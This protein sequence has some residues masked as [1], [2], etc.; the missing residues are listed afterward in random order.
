M[1]RCDFLVVG[2]GPAG[3]KAAVQAAKAGSQ[4]VLVEQDSALGGACVRRGTIPSKTLRETALALEGF[5]RRSGG[6]F[7][8]VLDEQQQVDSLMLRKDDVLAAHDRFLG[9]QLRRNGVDVWHGR[10]RF[11]DAHTLEVQP[12]VGA[13]RRVSAPI[14]IIATGSRPRTPPGIPVDHEHV[15]DSDSILSLAYLPRSLAVLG[16]GVIA[17]EYASIFAAL[18]VS[19]TVIDKAPRPLG[20]L[21]EEITDRWVSSFGGRFIGQV[22]VARVEWDGVSQVVTTLDSGEQVVTEKL[23]CALGRV[24]NVEQLNLPA[25][26]LQPTT[27]GLVEVDAHGRTA[28]S[29]IYAVGDAVGPPSLA[30]TSMEQGRRAALHA[31]GLPAPASSD[32]IPVGVFTIP[33]MAAVGLTEKQAAER[34][35]RVVVG[36]ARFDEVARGIIAAV[37]EGLLK[38]VVD[39]ESRKLLGIHIVGEGAAELVHVGQMAL[40][41][42]LPVETFVEHTFNFPTLAE[43]YRI[44]ALD[45]C[46]PRR[47]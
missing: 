19:V 41:G 39:V 44:A 20:F 31:L 3:Q 12:V 29:H 33:E 14:I 7:P 23:L 45:A 25:A 37:P 4:V 13:P 46:R 32:L 1:T 35:K 40:I 42:G 2:G 43:A 30:S 6:V 5:R 24:A 27:R 16:A 15:L 11:V 17:C 38:L 18:G 21:D 47:A 28:V 26:G 10:A 34:H 22:G 8:V 36:R 9:D